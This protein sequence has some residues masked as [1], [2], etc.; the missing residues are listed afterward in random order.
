MTPLF[1]IFQWP[2]SILL[3]LKQLH[4]RFD[5]ELLMKYFCP[6]WNPRIHWMNF[7]CVILILRFWKYTCI[8]S[9]FP[10]GKVAYLEKWS[11]I[12]ISQNIFLSIWACMRYFFK[13]I[14]ASEHPLPRFFKR[15][16]GTSLLNPYL[17]I[18]SH[19]SNFWVPQNSL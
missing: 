19:S 18:S 11:N 8:I 1:T 10:K 16:V 3:I 17:P 2:L 12:E 9:K 4:Y 15:E 7:R 13:N 5:I 6:I 14:C